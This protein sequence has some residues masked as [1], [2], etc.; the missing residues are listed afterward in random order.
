MRRED[1]TEGM[2]SRAVASR[3]D[4]LFLFFVILTKLLVRISVFGAKNRQTLGA[5]QP[6]ISFVDL[7]LATWNLEL[8][9]PA[10]SG[11]FEGR[12]HDPGRR[13]KDGSSCVQRLFLSSRSRSVSHRDDKVSELRGASG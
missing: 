2:R 1:E 7:Q 12:V 11:P 8:S 4:G 13:T 9:F 6:P 3:D 5:G 10:I